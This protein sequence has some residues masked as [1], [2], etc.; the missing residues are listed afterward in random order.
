MQRGPFVFYE[1]LETFITTYKNR[2]FLHIFKIQN[3]DQYY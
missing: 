1:R 2:D 3:A